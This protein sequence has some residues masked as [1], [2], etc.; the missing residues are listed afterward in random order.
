MKYTGL[1]ALALFAASPSNARECSS[2]GGLFEVMLDNVENPGLAET[3]GQVYTIFA[4]PLSKVNGA[5]LNPSRA[6]VGTEALGQGKL[7]ETLA[8]AMEHVRPGSFV[9]EFER[10][11]VS[12]GYTADGVKL[13]FR[14][15]QECPERGYLF[16]NQIKP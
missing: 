8:E 3:S 9:I 7:Y 10:G 6:W 16:K 13:E 2:N 5:I 14:L 4:S 11:K 12:G 15:F 1:L